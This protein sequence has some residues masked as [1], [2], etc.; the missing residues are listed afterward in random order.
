MFIIALS[1]FSK[2]L[3]EYAR[4]EYYSGTRRIHSIRK[5]QKLSFQTSILFYFIVAPFPYIYIE[6]IYAVNW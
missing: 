4:D 6:F 2:L 5:L 1:W 3:V